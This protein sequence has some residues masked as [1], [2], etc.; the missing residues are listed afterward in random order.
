MGGIPGA[1]LVGYSEPYGGD[2]LPALQARLVFTYQMVVA[3]D[4]AVVFTDEN[5]RIRRIAPGADG[6]VNGGPDEIVRTI[7]GFFSA[8]A[9]APSPYATSYYGN[10]R[11]LVEDPLSPG[12]FIASSHGGH[13]LLRF[14]IVPTGEGPPPPPGPAVVDI[15]EQITVNDGIDVLPSAM[16]E[17]T[18]TIAVNDGIVVLPSA[19]IELTEAIVVNDGIEVL[20]SVMLDGH[21]DDRRQR[22]SWRGAR[23]ATGADAFPPTSR[24]KPSA[25]PEPSSR[26]RRPR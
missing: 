8:V 1:N 4:G 21:R 12:S 19:M 24:V 18:E 13:V 5:H 26:S 11:G 23:D 17:L 2:G 9:A 7:A 14:G 20:P 15:T 16:V 22:R 6:V 10:F 3:A 25:R